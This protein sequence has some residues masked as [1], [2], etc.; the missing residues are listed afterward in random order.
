MSTI[1]RIILTEPYPETANRK[2]KLLTDFVA[3]S[4]D[5]LPRGE[6]HE[7]VLLPSGFLTFV[8]KGDLTN[9]SLAEPENKTEKQQWNAEI[10]DIKEQALAEFGKTFDN[11]T[12]KALK[13]V[14]NYLVVGIDSKPAPNSKEKT[15]EFVLVYDLQTGKPI[16]W[17]GKTHPTPGQ[18][19]CLI[20]MPIETHFMKQKVAGKRVAV[21][22]CNDLV[23]FN[24]RNTIHSPF[25]D[26]RNGRPRATD[27]KTG[28]RKCEMID[29][30]LAFKP[31]IVLQLAHTEGSWAAKW[32][33]LNK[34][35]EKSNAKPLKH[36][37]SCMK[38]YPQ[39]VTK[40]RD[41]LGNSQGGD[42]ATFVNGEF[43]E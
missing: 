9:V 11:T 43:V 19:Q 2:I 18:S 16:H 39:E 22:E 30:T 3:K 20:Q 37:A 34:W 26:E 28:K 14:A 6:K 17:T 7:F 24:P 21:F 10:D 31:E 1:S 40:R 5:A 38:K 8:I 12:L 4:K 29:A 35:L 36:F 25:K 42:V 32:T 13:S 23:I 15:I 41:K 33:T 27:T